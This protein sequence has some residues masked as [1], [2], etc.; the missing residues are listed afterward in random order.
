MVITCASVVF[1]F[2]VFLMFELKE[3]MTTVKLMK[4]YDEM[5][6][7]AIEQG[8]NEESL[9]GKFGGGKMSWRTGTSY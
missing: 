6:A 5:K 3:A 1:V 2:W 4:M 9:M 7:K 8:W